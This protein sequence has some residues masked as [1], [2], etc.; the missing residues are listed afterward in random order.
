M[1]RES[2]EKRE[3]IG[4]LLICEV[5]RNPSIL[6]RHSVFQGEKRY[7]PSYSYIILVY[8]LHTRKLQYKMHALLFDLFQFPHRQMKGYIM[9]RD[10]SKEDVHMMYY[11]VVQLTIKRQF[12][13]RRKMILEQQPLAVVACIITYFSE[14]C[15]CQTLK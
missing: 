1:S 3:K 12:Q 8:T 9:F 6:S 5:Q 10:S 15:H 14:T 2:S 11:T 4:K 7:N 13:V